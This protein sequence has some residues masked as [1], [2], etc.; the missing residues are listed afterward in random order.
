MIL[1]KGERVLLCACD[2]QDRSAIQT[3]A[4]AAAECGAV[5]VHWDTDRRWKTLLR[6]AFDSRAETVVGTSDTLLALSKLSKVNH[7]PLNIFHA[8]VVGVSCPN[9][10]L[11][12][13]ASGLDC[14]VWPCFN[15]DKDTADRRFMTGVTDRV[16]SD[17]SNLDANRDYLM[18]YGSILDCKLKRGDNNGMDLEVICFRGEKLPRFPQGANMTL[19]DWNPDTD[20]PLNLIPAFA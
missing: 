14:K 6:L 18:H 5:G 1:K 11:E 15:T 3:A 20:V 2:E 17:Y 10:I 4:A 12:S 16:T 9:W 8:V 19:R 13:I 7:I